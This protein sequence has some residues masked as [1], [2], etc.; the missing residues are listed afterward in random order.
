MHGEFTTSITPK[1]F[2]KRPLSSNTELFNLST[3]Q[4]STYQLHSNYDQIEFPVRE[5]GFSKI[6]KKEQH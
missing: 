5:K 6:E 1:S 2:Y 3:I 4:L